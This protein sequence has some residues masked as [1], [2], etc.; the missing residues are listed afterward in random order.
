MGRKSIS[1]LAKGILTQ[2]DGKD[3]AFIANLLAPDMGLSMGVAP[4]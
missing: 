1:S 3:K 4:L 2:L